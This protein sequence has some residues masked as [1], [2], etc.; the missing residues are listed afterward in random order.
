MKNNQL[1][2][3]MGLNQKG[4]NKH[5]KQICWR[6]WCW[7]YDTHNHFKIAE[8]GTPVNPALRRL[9]QE[10]HELEDSW[11]YALG[12]VPKGKVENLYNN[13]ANSCLWN[14]RMTV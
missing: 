14:D 13:E 4:R 10:D 5:E 6:F 9:Q 12:S 8:R 11:S 3:V 2:K 7:C 1:R